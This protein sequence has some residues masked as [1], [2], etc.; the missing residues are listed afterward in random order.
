MLVRYEYKDFLYKTK[1]VVTILK[2]T[3]DV[4]VEVII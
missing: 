4:E 3:R 2:T 1:N